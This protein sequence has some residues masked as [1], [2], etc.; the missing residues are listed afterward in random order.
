MKRFKSFFPFSR[1]QPCFIFKKKSVRENLSTIFCRVSHHLLV[2]YL[3]VHE[4]KM[5]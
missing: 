1:F 2:S 3:S 5:Y 4:V